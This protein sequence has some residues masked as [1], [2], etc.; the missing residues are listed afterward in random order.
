MNTEETTPSNDWQQRQAQ[1]SQQVDLLMAVCEDL[2]A[3]IAD[4]PGAAKAL[5]IAAGLLAT[6]SHHRRGVPPW[7]RHQELVKAT[8]AQLLEELG[9]V[10]T[11]KIR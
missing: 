6:I 7:A 3:A 8:Q 11:R 4:R 9:D 1:R 10:E 5:G 2:L